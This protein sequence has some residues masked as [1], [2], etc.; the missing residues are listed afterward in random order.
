MSAG[1]G[2]AVEHLTP[3]SLSDGRE[4]LI[5]PGAQTLDTTGVPDV[6]RGE[7]VQILGDLDR[8]DD[9]LV[10]LP[11]TRSKWALVRNRVLNGF[12]THMTGEVFDV[13]RRHSIL[14]KTIDHTPWDDES[15]LRGVSRAQASG[16][17]L[18]HLFGV[19]AATLMEDLKP[20]TTGAF[21]SGLVIGHVEIEAA[22]E[23][24]AEADTVIH[25]IASRSL[26]TCTLVRW[27][28][29]GAKPPRVRRPCIRQGLWRFDGRLSL[30]PMGDDAGRLCNRCPLIAILRGVRPTKSSGSAKVWSMLGS[31]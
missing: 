16:G 28:I 4:I 2:G 8:V 19:R 31:R 27:M 23:G 7:E 26:S 14:G 30:K 5:A 9:G 3:V 6:M 1:V 29:A 17:L 15:L 22:L 11:G 24:A 12:Q 21:L 10:C 18:H 13:L 20:E 25:L